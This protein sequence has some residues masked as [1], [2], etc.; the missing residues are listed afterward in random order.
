MKPSL[1]QQALNKASWPGRFEK[2]DKV[3]LDG[4][5]NVDGIKSLIK[6][7]IDQN[8]D[9][10]L[11]IFSALQDKDTKIM[12]DLLCRYSIIEASFDDERLKSDAPDFKK[13]LKDNW[14]DHKN[15]VV[16]GSL[17]FISAVRKYLVA[18]K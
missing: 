8:I 1:L 15:I 10:V 13:V 18:K 3:Y 6:T 7:L 12:K 5:H 9:D 17:H 14:N 4:A 16:T 2:I 11:I